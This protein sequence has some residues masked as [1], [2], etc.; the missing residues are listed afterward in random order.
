MQVLLN[1]SVAAER[2]RGSA[3]EAA[4]AGACPLSAAPLPAGYRDH[5]GLSERRKAEVRRWGGGGEDRSL[6]PIR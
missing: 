5:K 6:A 4:A 1:F 2:E 3:A